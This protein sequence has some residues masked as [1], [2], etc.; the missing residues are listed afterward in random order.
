MDAYAFTLTLPFISPQNSTTLEPHD[1]SILG[2]PGRA[3]VLDPRFHGSI[4]ISSLEIARHLAADSLLIR[5]INY[6]RSAFVSVSRAL[7]SSAESSQAGGGGWGGGME[8]LK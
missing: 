5:A 3:V 1:Y 4:R 2:G 6:P 8:S 7:S